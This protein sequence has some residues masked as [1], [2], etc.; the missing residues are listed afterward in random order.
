MSE[1]TITQLPDP[2]GFTADPL[3]DLVRDG[4]RKLLQ[5]ASRLNLRRCSHPMPVNEP[6]M[7]V[8]GWFVTA[9]CRSAM[10]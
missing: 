10:C 2:S 4:A 1:D 9:T 6:R 3:T 8:H 7:V 5:K